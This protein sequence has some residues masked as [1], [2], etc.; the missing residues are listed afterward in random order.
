VL[1]LCAAPGGKTTHLAALM[2]D[3]GELVSVEQHPGRADALR[4]TCERMGV[5][6]ARVVVGDAAAFEGDRR[7]DRVLADP[8]CSG[9]GTLQARPDLRWRMTHERIAGLIA[10]QRAILAAAARAVRPG[11]V[12]VWSTCTLNPAE[13]EELLAEAEGLTVQETRTLLPHETLSAGFMITR[14]LSER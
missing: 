7:F 9:L 13:N 3:E 1:D 12:L 8:P 11:G 4:R 5:T 14:L 10:E 6:C 2:R